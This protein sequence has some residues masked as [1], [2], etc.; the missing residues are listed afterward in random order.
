[1]QRCQDFLLY[2]PNTPLLE[3]FNNLEILCR[4]AGRREVETVRLDDQEQARD[5][6][7]L[8]LD[9]QGGEADVLRGA[10][11]VLEETVVVHT[12]V[13]FVPLYRSQ[14][15]FAEIDQLL[16][17]PGFLFHKFA[18]PAGRSFQPIVVNN[19]P[20]RG[21]SQLLWADA[22]YVK[23]FLGFDQLPPA[24]LLKLAV[25]YM[26][27][28]SPLICQ[29]WRCGT[30]TSRRARAWRMPTSSGWCGPRGRHPGRDHPRPA[31]SPAAP[32]E[33]LIPGHLLSI[34]V[35]DGC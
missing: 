24:K 29:P 13:E 27:S 21:L 28:T 22:V 4:V 15:L 2:E 32:R 20:N 33:K 9:V 35:S 3:R 7:Y 1:M 5:T 26:R 10:E 14:P 12:E 6:D 8:K 31:K 23:S 16:R 30:T 18:G 25:I 11:R 34:R 19:D 17:S